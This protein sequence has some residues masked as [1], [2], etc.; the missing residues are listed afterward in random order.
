MEI[1]NFCEVLLDQNDNFS[2][3]VFFLD[4]QNQ[5]AIYSGDRFF[6]I[7]WR[8]HIVCQEAEN[9]IKKSFSI[10]ITFHGSSPEVKALCV[11]WSSE[12]Y[13]YTF[14][15]QCFGKKY[16]PILMGQYFT[17]NF[18]SCSISKSGPVSWPP[19]SL[20]LTPWNI[21]TSYLK[22]AWFTLGPSCRK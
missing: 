2:S 20:G 7:R 14:V 1:A 18:G 4:A 6:Q 11:I 9:S 17:Q 5:A 8:A 15:Q 10:L 22:H 13:K 12:G 3:F 19:R 21:L 16:F